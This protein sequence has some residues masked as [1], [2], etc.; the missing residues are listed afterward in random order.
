MLWSSA[1]TSET[2]LIFSIP[3]GP[4]QKFTFISIKISIINLVVLINSVLK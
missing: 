3:E 4:P 2:V 1:V